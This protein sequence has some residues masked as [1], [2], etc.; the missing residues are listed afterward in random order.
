MML[1]GLSPEQERYL[2]SA[3]VLQKWLTFSLRQRVMLANRIFFGDR[4]VTVYNLREL[5]ARHCVKLR[6]LHPAVPH[7]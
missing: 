2:V 1:H 6:S 7:T 5:Y 3:E 4:R